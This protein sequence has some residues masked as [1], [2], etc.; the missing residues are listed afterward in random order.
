MSDQA[1][2]TWPPTPANEK[3]SVLLVIRLALGQ[4]GVA[5][6]EPQI[7]F[8]KFDRPPVKIFISKF[9]LCS[10]TRYRVPVSQAIYFVLPHF[11]PAEFYLPPQTIWLRPRCSLLG[12]WAR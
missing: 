10:Y 7:S 11:C 3:A 4:F 2:I 9:K 1:Y 6:C 5:D 12:Q 8:M